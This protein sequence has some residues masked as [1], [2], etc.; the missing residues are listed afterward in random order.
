MEYYTFTRELLNRFPKFREFYLDIRKA[1]EINLLPSN[2]G[3]DFIHYLDQPSL[4]NGT[5]QIFQDLLSDMKS[6]GDEELIMLYNEILDDIAN[7]SYLK[8]ELMT[9]NIIFDIV[10]P[11]ALVSKDE[12]RAKLLKKRI[13]IDYTGN[14]YI[15]DNKKLLEE[16]K[17]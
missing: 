5:I 4:N 2:L 1:N 15:E 17:K 11:Y 7:T 6:S 3:F 10:D 8:N 12:A 16:Y 9:R 13:E 14:K